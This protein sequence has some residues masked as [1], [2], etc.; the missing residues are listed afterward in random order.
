MIAEC[1]ICPHRCELRNGEVGRCRIRKNVDGEIKPL[2]Y[3][4]PCALHVDPVEKKP[5]FH[6]LPG[7]R[8]FSVATAGCNLR[9]RNCQNWEIS[10]AEPDDVRTYDAPP[11]KIVEL[12]VK[13]K[14]AS[15]AY[16]YTE[17][18][19]FY[20]YTRDISVLAKEKGIRNILVTAGYI[21]RK[22][23][24]RLSKSVDAANIDLKAFSDDFYKDV[25]GARLKPVLESLAASKEFGIMVEVT[26]LV[27][28]TLNDTPEMIT[29]LCKWVARE[30]G[31]DTP[32]HFSRFHPNYR[33]R[34]LPPTPQKTLE[35]AR[36]I[37]REAGLEYV[38]IG[39]VLT[40]DGETTACPG[41]GKVLIR[42]RGF[43]V[44]ENR[45][46]GTD[47][48]CPECKRKIHGVWK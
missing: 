15:I 13:H 47:G 41:C 31:V 38:Y 12:A 29:D 17:P 25:C 30:M 46:A 7:S 1:T 5:L 3:G 9:C 19:V 37:A 34:N 28:P 16:T 39:N 40:E 32:L 10:Q 21:N 42:R 22:P 4:K 20:E 35:K 14:C 6:F 23:L 45:M 33:M 2:T 18:I 8:A 48:N 27:I 43:Q 24:E 26:N 44:V 36:T 11:R